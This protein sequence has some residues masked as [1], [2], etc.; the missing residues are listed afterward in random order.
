ML[1]NCRGIRERDYAHPSLAQEDEVYS[2]K[3]F[4]NLAS[5]YPLLVTDRPCPGRPLGSTGRVFPRD[6]LKQDAARGHY[7]LL[8]TSRGTGQQ[9]QI[10]VARRCIK[11]GIHLADK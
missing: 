5:V 9:Q 1:A 6:L 4:P 8:R 7:Y 2:L 11:R 10:K 3:Q